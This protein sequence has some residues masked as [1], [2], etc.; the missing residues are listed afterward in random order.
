M[1]T[2]PEHQTAIGVDDDVALIKRQIT[3]LREL[4][5][6]GSVSEDEIYDFS[7]RW[8]TVLAGRVRRLAHY[9][10]LG[11]L[12]EADAAKFQALRDELDELTGLIERFRLTRPR[13]AGDASAP[14][15]RL[16]RV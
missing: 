12:A 7:I 13:L 3:A 5:G 1:S 11:L 2:Q 4:G 9:S 15:R 8:G 10:A 16:R 14:H 6:R